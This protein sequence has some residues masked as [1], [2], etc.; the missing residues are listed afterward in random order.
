MLRGHWSIYNIHNP[1][2]EPFQFLVTS[3]I[4]KIQEMNIE[5]IWR[6]NI[7]HTNS[8]IGQSSL[9][10]FPQGRRNSPNSIQTIV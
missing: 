5:E 6:K 9:I 10:Q 8:F 7:I 1:E 2:N 3:C 4:C